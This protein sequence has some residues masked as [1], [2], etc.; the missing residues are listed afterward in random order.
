MSQTKHLTLNHE[1]LC[2]LA[3]HRAEPCLSL[4]LPVDRTRPPS[5]HEAQLHN[6]LREAEHQLRSR[7][8]PTELTSEVR[9]AASDALS[10]ESVDG[11][12]ALFADAEAI[13]F[14][15]VPWVTRPS[16]FVGGR[17]VV[18]QLSPAEAQDRVFVVA[19]SR[20][21]VR[22]LDIDRVGA[23]PVEL[24]DLP[25]GGTS[26]VPGAD[27]EHNG[28]QAHSAGKDAVF[29]GHRDDTKGNDELISR[30]CRQTAEALVAAMPD[31]SMPVVVAAV[32]RLAAAFV[33]AASELE[34]I[35]TIH[36]NAD[37]TPDHVLADAAREALRDHRREQTDAASEALGTAI[38]AGLG[39]TELTEVV[40]A[41]ADGRV[42]TLY[43][44]PSR[45]VRG[46][47]DRAS[48]EVCLDETGR[49]DLI[50]LAI[51]ETIRYGGEIVPRLPGGVGTDEAF[52][53]ALYRHA[54]AS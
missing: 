27:A 52:V 5:A 50:D 41:A 23:R 17:F 43:V 18:R 7:G 9:Q 38:H 6:L 45:Q 21:A 53:V 44:D 35:T 32:E 2:A 47:Y 49:D 8:W 12:V 4:Y 15:N 20:S 29:H 11:S 31:R 40:V 26:D 22:V 10:E 30:L 14:V 46:E 34:V 48:R 54:L 51:A 16:C 24:P 42:H 39:S 33:S 28:L 25:S 1:T 37:D 3:D 36:G 13:R 19:L